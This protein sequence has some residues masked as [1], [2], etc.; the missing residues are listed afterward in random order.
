MDFALNRII[1]KKINKIQDHLLTNNQDTWMSIKDA[2]QYTKLSDSTI[3]RAIKK[4][5]LKVSKRTGK[6]LFQRSWIN[7]WLGDNNEL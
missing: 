6:N 1:L 7:Q 4:G 2:V 3:R 5:C